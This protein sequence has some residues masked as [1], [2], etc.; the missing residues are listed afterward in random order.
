[1]QAACPNAEQPEANVVEGS[2]FGVLDIRRIVD[3]AGNEDD[4]QNADG[5]VD[6][7][8]IAP[9]ESVG[10]P[11]A[12]R[13]AKDR[14]DDD[15]ETIGGHG[16][17]AFC[18]GKALKQDGLRQRLQCAA[19]RTLQHA[20]QQNDGERWGRSAEKRGN[21]EDG[22]ADEQEPLAS[23]AAGEPVGGGQN[24]GVGDQ[25]AGENPGGFR[26]GS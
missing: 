16:H 19:P 5:N 11:A 8:G 6:V 3:E 17:G 4:R 21:G 1:M 23:E 14:G 26:V 24:D 20:G 7:K 12:Q 9:A 13:G 18:R 2:H 15:P 10:K 22:D 25:V